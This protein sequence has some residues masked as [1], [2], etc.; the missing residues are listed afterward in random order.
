MA[1]EEIT[2][3]PILL[4]WKDLEYTIKVPPKDQTALGT[5]LS[6]FKFGEFSEWKGA[7]FHIQMTPFALLVKTA[8]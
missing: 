5:S 1:E 4:E 2:H 6:F 3:Q 8:V 7:A